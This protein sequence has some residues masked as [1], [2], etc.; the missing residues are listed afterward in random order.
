MK[1]NEL[2]EKLRKVPEEAKKTIGAGRLKGMTDVNPMW[3]IKAMTDTFGPCGFGW[4]YEIDNQWLEQ[5]GQE[6]KAFC[7]VSLYVKVGDEWSEAIPGTGGSSFVTVEKGGLYVNDEAHKMALTDA[8]SVAM[9]ALGVAADVYFSKG[10]DLETKY[11]LP[12][13]QQRMNE[14]WQAKD[15]DKKVKVV[16]KLIEEANTNE[17]LDQIGRANRDVMGETDVINA[18]R[19]A[20]ARITAAKMQ[21][22]K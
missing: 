21:A 7:N 12:Q 5:A 15:L 16:V 4:R 11:E 9:K 13:S 14:E 20:R 3:R 8:L 2:Y 18:G 6:V 10:R 19:A 17:E 1:E 22:T